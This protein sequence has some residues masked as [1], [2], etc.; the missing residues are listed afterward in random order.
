MG[1][2]ETVDCKTRLLKSLSLLLEKEPLQHQRKDSPKEAYQINS[3]NKVIEKHKI[4]GKFLGLTS[5]M[6]TSTT[7]KMKI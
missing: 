7:I 3:K 4:Q 5:R 1:L 6:E 2:P